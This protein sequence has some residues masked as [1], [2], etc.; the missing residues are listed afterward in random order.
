M[1]NN[2]RLEALEIKCAHLENTVES[3]SDALYRQ[4]QAVAETQASARRLAARLD[5]LL[6]ASGPGTEPDE[7]PPHY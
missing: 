3:L 7:R 5:E 4:Q 1:S 2:N 6:H